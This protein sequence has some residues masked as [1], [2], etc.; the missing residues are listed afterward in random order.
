MGL[1][2]EGGVW[3]WVVGVSVCLCVA[4]GPRRPVLS[5]LLMAGRVTMHY[6][7]FFIHWAKAVRGLPTADSPTSPPSP[8]NLSLRPLPLCFSRTAPYTSVSS[9]VKWLLTSPYLPA[10]LIACLIDK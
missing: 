5:P 2:E 7:E 3:V 4:S 9:Q 6:L 10:C 8:W 1:G